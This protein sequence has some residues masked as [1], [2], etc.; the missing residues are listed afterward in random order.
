MNTKKILG[1]VTI[2]VIVGGTIYAIKKSKD[3]Q[4]T[5]EAVI[6]LDEA[7]AMMR[8]RQEAE[9]STAQV[10]ERFEMT[11]EEIEELV[12]DAREEVNWNASFEVKPED[13]A[14]SIEG[15]V[16]PSF[17]DDV[18]YNIPL[19]EIMTE[20]DKVL[21]FEP[22]SQKALEQYIKMELA[23][24]LPMEPSYQA[25]LRLSSFPFEPKNDGDHILLTQ[26]I[27]YRAGFF[28]MASI[29][30][31]QV[32][33]ADVILHYARLTDFNCGGGVRSWVDHILEHNQFDDLRTSAQIDE[34]IDRLN[35]H[36]YFNEELV[37]FGLFGL[38]RDQMD[39]AARVAHMNIDK[40]LTYEIEYNVFLQSCL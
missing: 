25:M 8:L 9:K 14:D 27:D 21:R 3:I 16:S 20:E 1:I 37:T 10:A 6:S 18:D 26:I 22:N 17:Y 11:E 7:R 23:E 15:G 4:R 2:T 33:F 5:D 39:D 24:W 38:T 32:S 40:Q 28:G 12:D 29:W 35:D 36:T 30:T 19:A 34:A 31:Q 13:R